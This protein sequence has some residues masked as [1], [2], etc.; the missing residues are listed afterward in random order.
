MN[1]GDKVKVIEDVWDDHREKSWI[2]WEGTVLG[3]VSHPPDPY[4]IFVHFPTSRGKWRSFDFKEDELELVNEDWE[5]W[6][7]G[8]DSKDKEWAKEVKENELKHTV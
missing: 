3:T 8:A 6:D 1:I 2:G 4:N 5:T 7:N